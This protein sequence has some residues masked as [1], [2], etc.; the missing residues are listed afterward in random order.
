MIKAF[1][2]K[3]WTQLRRTYPM[4]I[5]VLA[6]L[7]TGAI[8]PIIIKYTPAILEKE[9]LDPSSL[10]GMISFDAPGSWASFF[11]NVRQL[12]LLTLVILLALE[13]GKEFRGQALVLMLGRGLPRSTAIW[14]KILSGLLVWTVACLVSYLACGLLTLSLFGQTI[15]P[16]LWVPLAYF[17]LYGAV[18]VFVTVAGCAMAQGIFG[19]FLASGGFV[20][21]T[22][23]IS[24]WPSADN[25]NPA[26]MAARGPAILAQPSTQWDY[27]PAALAAIAVAA[28]SVTMATR[29]YRG[30]KASN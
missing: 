10:L 19:G 13:A 25:Y 12:G 16:G 21:I 29:W 2:K 7:V 22:A 17:W 4:A 23:L 5:L 8:S 18:L 28:A 11:G 3:E 27:L 26:S 9:G 20:A 30:K 24:L 6:M 14:A 1:L 15:V